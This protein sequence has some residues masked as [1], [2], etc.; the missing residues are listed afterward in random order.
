METLKP[1]RV[2][3]LMFHVCVL[4]LLAE[5]YGDLVFKFNKIVGRTDFSDQ[6]RKI[7]IQSYWLQFKCDATVC[8]LS[9]NHITVNN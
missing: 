2:S 9:F 5:F 7:V 4:Q 6:F 1:S 8:M 3:H